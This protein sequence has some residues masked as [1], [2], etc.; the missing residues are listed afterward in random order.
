MNHL[1]KILIDDDGES[2]PPEEQTWC[3]VSPNPICDTP[4][5]L[6]KSEVLDIDTDAVWKSKTVKKGGITCQDCIQIVKAFKAV[7]L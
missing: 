6:C 1:V 5:T 2:I 3:L 7:K 4:R